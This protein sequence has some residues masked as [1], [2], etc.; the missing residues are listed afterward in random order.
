M[1]NDTAK[2]RTVEDWLF[3]CVNHAV[4]EETVCQIADDRNIPLNAASKDVNKNTLR[5]LKADLLK[6]IVLGP[7]K[8]NDTKDSDNGWS[9][10]GGGYTLDKN[11]KKLL[12]KEANDIYEEL[13][14][15]SVF[16][17]TRIRM[18]SAG[19]MPTYYDVDGNPIPRK[20]L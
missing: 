14:P 13:E 9:H 17:K 7:S 18:R 20:P 4:P 16:G 19:V 8:V 5:L 6:W 15:E 1:S 10:S 11:D 3:G 12:M 2:V